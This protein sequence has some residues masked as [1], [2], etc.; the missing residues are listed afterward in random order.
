MSPASTKP[1][2]DAPPRPATSNRQLGRRLRQLGVSGRRMRRTWTRERFAEIARTLVWVIP[3]TLLVWVWAQDQQIEQIVQ[4]NIPLQIEHVDGQRVIEILDPDVRRGNNVIQLRSVTFQGP[5][6][7]LST[8]TNRLRNDFAQDNLDIKLRAGVADRVNVD[9]RDQLNDLP[10]L[11]ELGVSVVE[12]LPV[13]VAVRVEE[14]K[15]V[16]GRIVAGGMQPEELVGPPTFDPPTVTVEGPASVIELLSDERGEIPV[17][18]LLPDPENVPAGQPQTRE[19][20]LQLPEDAPGLSLL[21]NTV[22]ASFTRAER[23][24]ISAT[25][26]KVIVKA[27]LP[28]AMSGTHAVEVEP[29]VLN[30]VPIQGPADIVRRIESGAIPVEAELKVVRDDQGNEGPIRRQVEF[31]LPQGVILRQPQEVT[32]TLRRIGNGI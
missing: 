7:G 13:Q 28:A 31:N 25:L 6:I 4:Q 27:S 26:P 17:V 5:R 3:L 16:T 2:A 32:F 29:T 24:V 1:Q 14:R 22:R 12:V 9:L 11:R 30:N 18:A 10:V 19:V 15:T 20:P 21:T 8:L 23:Q